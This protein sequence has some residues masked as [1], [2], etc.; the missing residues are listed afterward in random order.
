MYWNSRSG[1]KW[2]NKSQM[3]KKLQNQNIY[4]PITEKKNEK[5]SLYYSS[6]EVFAQEIVIS[7]VMISSFLSPTWISN[8][9]CS[10][11]LP[12]CITNNIY[13]R[14]HIITKLNIDYHHIWIPSW[15]P[16][17]SYFSIYLE[18]ISII[19]IVAT[20]MRFRYYKLIVFHDCR[21]TMHHI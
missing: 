15:I 6:F 1:R 3:E 11:L 13:L 21:F 16:P 5:S 17:Y 2:K 4:S 10:L 7:I 19:V 12:I 20:I 8:G 18:V 14:K 9:N